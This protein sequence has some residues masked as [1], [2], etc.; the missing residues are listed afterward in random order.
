MGVAEASDQ[1]RNDATPTDVTHA[2]G[3]IPPYSANGSQDEPT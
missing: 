2:S 1:A 3:L